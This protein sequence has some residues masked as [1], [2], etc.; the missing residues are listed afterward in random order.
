M[1]DWSGWPCSFGMI[2]CRKW[3]NLAVAMC[4]LD[5]LFPGTLGQARPKAQFYIQLVFKAS[6]RIKPWMVVFL[7]TNEMLPKVK[8]NTLM[9]CNFLVDSTISPNSFEFIVS[10]TKSWK[11]HPKK[12]LRKTQI[13][14]FPIVPWL[15]KRPKQK[16]SCFKIW[17]IDQLY[18][19]LGPKAS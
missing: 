14:F 8:K 17:L 6:L 2:S 19:E 11:N 12:L 1:Y 13:H 16:N 10:P 7:T 4:V 5:F 3:H 15:P 9:L 18:I